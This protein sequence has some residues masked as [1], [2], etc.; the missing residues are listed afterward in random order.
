MKAAVGTRDGAQGKA[1]KE[2]TLEEG[3]ILN[4]P[5]LLTFNRLVHSWL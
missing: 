2:S 3:P 1:N 4:L 5:E